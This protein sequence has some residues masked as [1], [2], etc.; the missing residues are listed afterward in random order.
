MFLKQGPHE[1][2]NFGSMVR[3]GITGNS[4]YTALVKN[5]AVYG[6][7]NY[8][9][10]DAIVATGIVEYGNYQIGLSYDFTVSRLASASAGRGAMEFNL[11]YALSGTKARVLTSGVK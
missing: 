7:I 6:G 10:R 9:L 2:L 11:R 1:L 3:L 8:R 4:K 5:Y